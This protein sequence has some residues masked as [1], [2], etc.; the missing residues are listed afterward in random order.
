M[1]LSEHRKLKESTRRACPAEG[2]VCASAEEPARHIERAQR[3][4]QVDEG[5]G[6]QRRAPRAC[7]AAAPQINFLHPSLF[8][9]S[10]LLFWSLL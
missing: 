10:L 6:S 2:H 7:A 5:P 3:A 9:L 8:S 4:G 1:T